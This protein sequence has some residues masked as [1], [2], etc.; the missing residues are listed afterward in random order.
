MEITVPRIIKNPHERRRDIIDAAHQ[1][2]K[3]KGYAHTTMQDVM[4]RLNI[5]KGTIYHYFTSKEE[6]L[7]AVVR[8]IV[9]VNF[10]EMTSA[11]ESSK[12]TALANFKLLIK[13]GNISRGNADI[14]EQ[15]H[16]PSN[17]SMHCRLLAEI[18]TKHATLYAK[19]IEQGN[20]E[21]IFKAK[22]PLECAEFFL[23][24]M[25]FLTDVGFYPWSSKDLTRRAKAFPKILEQ[26]LGAPSGS[27]RFL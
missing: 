11:L 8:D 2:F 14:L 22:N 9:D 24:G 27:F 7:E 17:Q 10:L 1:L 16:R 23:S 13:K 21:G 20:E 6:L 19:V 18:I 25:Q 26:L 12:K 4:Q 15:L 3:A 5:A